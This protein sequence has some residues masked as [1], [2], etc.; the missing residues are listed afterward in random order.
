L[1]ATATKSAKAVP[2]QTGGTPILLEKLFAFLAGTWFGLS[3]LKFG[4]P[5]ILDRMVEAP[6]DGLEFLIQ[7]WPVAW[8][9]I[10]GVIVI[11]AAL[12]LVKIQWRRDFWPA[13]LLIF[14]FFWTVLSN[15]QSVAPRLSHPTLLHFTFCI[16]S[17][18]IGLFAFSRCRDDK[19]FWIPLIL[20]FSYVLFNAFDQRN[21]GLES[22]RKAFYE[23]PDWQNYPPEFKLKLA[24][25]RIFSTLVYPNALAG[26]VLLLLP[27]LLWQ[28]WK[29]TAAWPRVLRGV[30]TGLFGYLSIAT[31]YWTGSKGGW[32][33]A[34]AMAGVLVLQ[35]DFSRKLKLILLTL[36]VIVGLAGFAIKFSAYFKKGAPSV[37]ARFVYWQAAFQIAKDHPLLGTGPG[38]FQIPFKEI[39]PPEAE[40]ARLVH[41]DYLEQASDSGFPA[42]LGYSGFIF[43]ILV[44]L[45]RYSAQNRSDFLLWLGLAG[46]AVQGFIEFGLY[47]PAL[48]WPTLF[49]FG[50]LSGKKPVSTSSRALNPDL[51]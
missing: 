27:V 17:F 13:G 19:W 8:G 14:W 29:L 23:Q 37:G 40:M 41:N 16:L 34:I 44:L 48:S 15:S 2:S 42:F 47:I 22:M 26:A 46:W 51:R 6:K 33:I 21:G 18:F 1:K 38:T 45:Y 28:L 43:A 36:G 20:A 31:L 7:P 30:V 9:Y 5:I 25:N 11:L 49:F 4:N 50:W 32:L 10:F 35:L 24:T 12:P 3:L 39:K